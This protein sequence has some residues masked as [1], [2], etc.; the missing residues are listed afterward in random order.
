MY[1]MRSRWAAR[2]A[3]FGGGVVLIGGKGVYGIWEAKTMIILCL[4]VP[5]TTG[6]LHF[7]IW[8]DFLEW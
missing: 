6:R 5:F 7:Q 2:S 3:Q 4:L 1:R 8:P